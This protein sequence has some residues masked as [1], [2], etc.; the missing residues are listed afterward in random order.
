MGSLQIGFLRNSNLDTR[1]STW[2]EEKKSF[3]ENEKRLLK[4]YKDAHPSFKTEVNE[5]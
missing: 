1:K 5:I 4:I 2:N 3:I